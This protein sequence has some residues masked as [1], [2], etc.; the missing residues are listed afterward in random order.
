MNWKL[1]NSIR[2][3]NLIE[4][5]FCLW[6]KNFSVR[7]GSCVVNWGSGLGR[8]GRIDVSGLTVSVVR[9]SEFIEEPWSIKVLCRERWVAMFELMMKVWFVPIGLQFCERERVICGQSKWRIVQDVSIREEIS[10]RGEGVVVSREG[11]RKKNNSM[12]YW[13]SGWFVLKNLNS[14][15][16]GAFLAKKDV[17][18]NRF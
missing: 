9:D 17:S 10:E 1:L 18:L 4:G 12:Q 13:S 3:Y 15:Q 2:V 6:K 8:L 11:C 5:Q 14:Q 7:G 16:F